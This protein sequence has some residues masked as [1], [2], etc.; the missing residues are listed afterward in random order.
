MSTTE[1]IIP[2]TLI[3][4]LDASSS[5]NAFDTLKLLLG[6]GALVKQ[7]KNIEELIVIKYSDAPKVVLRQE[8]KGGKPELTV[9]KL[10]EIYTINGS[11]SMNDA[12][13]MACDESDKCKPEVSVEGDPHCIV[14]F[15]TDGEEN[16]SKEKRVGVVKERLVITKKSGCVFLCMGIPESIAV[17]YGLSE[18][19]CI[20]YSH[21]DICMGNVW[22]SA[23]AVCR[24]YSSGDK[25][26]LSFSVQQRENSSDGAHCGGSIEADLDE[27]DS[28]DE[29]SRTH[30]PLERE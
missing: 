19:Q 6:V 13:L 23:A 2:K 28:D 11:T 14:I 29:D 20:E 7:Q 8:V 27:E 25:E 17:T 4:V 26:G 5:M 18:G 24:A 22:E 21:N 1:Q 16:T 9:E 3:V 10:S 30:C 12:F 15:I